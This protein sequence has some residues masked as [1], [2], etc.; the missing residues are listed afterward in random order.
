MKKLFK[1]M[2][3]MVFILSSINYA[4]GT[5][6]ESSENR[7]ELFPRKGCYYV[8]PAILENA[9]P[10]PEPDYNF[11]T[12]KIPEDLDQLI[13]HVLDPVECLPYTFPEMSE[14]DMTTDDESRLDR[15]FTRITTTTEFPYRTIGKLYSRWGN[16]WYVGS[17]A[18]MCSG[19]LLFTAGHNLYHGSTSG[20]WSYADQVVF[21]PGKD[22]S[23]EP[24]GQFS[25]TRFGVP[26]GWRYDHDWEHDWGI[27]EISES[28]GL[29]W[30]GWQY[31]DDPYWYIDRDVNMTGYP[32]GCSG[33]GWE[34]WQNYDKITYATDTKLWYDG[35]SY[36]GMSG[37]PIWHLYEIGRAHV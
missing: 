7:G 22:G 18:F 3:I 16:D 14:I 31:R 37:G 8:D 21:I 1:H 10:L 6:Y 24:Y 20:T 26:N 33:H 32:E 11:F 5:V 36:G 30:M 15:S 13:T 9:I 34:M 27:A 12:N 19:Y 23:Y 35:T 4:L 2:I 28:A 25:V 17:A 29:G